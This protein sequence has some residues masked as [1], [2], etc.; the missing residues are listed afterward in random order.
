MGPVSVTSTPPRSRPV[1]TPPPHL[2]G[3][4]WGWPPFGQPSQG[5]RGLGEV[6]V[7]SVSSP[8]AVPSDG[9]TGELPR[10]RTRRPTHRSLTQR[11]RGSPSV[12]SED[13]VSRQCSAPIAP[14]GY[15]PRP[16]SRSSSSQPLARPCESGL[17]RGLPTLTLGQNRPA[18]RRPET[19]AKASLPA[20]PQRHTFRFHGAAVASIDRQLHPLPYRRRFTFEYGFRES[21]PRCTQKPARK[22]ATGRI[23]WSREA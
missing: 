9:R 10:C 14:S 2:A 1:P 5:F 6:L 23:R 21:S 15:P 12:R 13:A 16:R 7:P 11:H 8:P 20:T 18:N 19:L 17:C 4:P 22:I 3:Y